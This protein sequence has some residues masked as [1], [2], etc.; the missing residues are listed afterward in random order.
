LK[1]TPSGTET[2]EKRKKK[3]DPLREHDAPPDETNHVASEPPQKDA[4]KAKGSSEGHKKNKKSGHNTPSK[5]QSATEGILETSGDKRVKKKKKEDKGE[6]A[7]LKQGDVSKET[8]TPPELVAPSVDD[9]SKNEKKVDEVEANHD[10]T[11]REAAPTLE[12]LASQ[13]DDAKGEKRKKKGKEE[14]AAVKKRKHED[15]MSNDVEQRRK[16]NR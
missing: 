4:S 1:H 2:K 16:K 13:T 15:A 14:K 12:P 10:S 7:R 11:T 3:H 6:K 9:R 5:T 8:N